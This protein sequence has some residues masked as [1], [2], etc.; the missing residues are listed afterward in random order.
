MEDLRRSAKKYFTFRLDTQ[1]L[2]GFVV[3]VIGLWLLSK[4]IT[5]STSCDYSE[6][7]YSACGTGNDFEVNLRIKILLIVVG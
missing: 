3:I 6:Q 7:T 1:G 4:R 5:I 2:F